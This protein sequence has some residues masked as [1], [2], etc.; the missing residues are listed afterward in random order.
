MPRCPDPQSRAIVESFLHNAIVLDDIMVISQKGESRSDPR[1]HS[2]IESPDYPVFSDPS[3]SASVAE[4]SGV[5]LH[6]DTVINGFADLGIVCAALTADS[7]GGFSLRT[8]KAAV[9][10]DI[11]VLDWT[12]GTS[13]GS[14]TLEVMKSI[15]REDE[16]NPRLRLI[17]IYTGE[18]NLGDIAEQVQRALRDFNGDQNPTIEEKIRVSYGQVRVVIVAKPGTLN[19]HLVELGYEEVSEEDLA[20][21][22]VDEF[23]RLTAG[24][25]RNVALAGI[26]TI[27]KNS[28][29]VLARFDSTLDPAYL[30]HR[31]LLPHPPDAEDHLVAALASEF[32]SIL[33][34]DRPGG[35]AD[36]EAIDRWLK[37]D[38][39]P[40]ISQRLSFG[41]GGNDIER[42]L[43]LLRDGIAADGVRLPKGGKKMVE[44]RATEL[45]S[46]DVTDVA[47]ANHQFAAL[48][49]L[50]TRYPGQPPRLTIG[51]VLCTE[52]AN[53]RQFLLC[54]QP[55]CDSI[56]LDCRS[57]FVFVPL[58]VADDGGRKV[59]FP[60]VV[61]IQGGE[62]QQLG[63]DLRPLELVV[64]LFCPGVNPPGEI[65]AMEEGPGEF[66]FKDADGQ[67]Y[68]WIAELK[69]EHAFR[70]AGAIASA[71]ARP[72]PNDAE[73][74]RR[75]GRSAQ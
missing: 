44:P 39:A 4:R 28:H 49:N 43:D 10:A 65:L 23:A 52:A 9:R 3:D 57:R 19:P 1:P 25:I 73:W 26:A 56:R 58:E 59:S 50:K 15:L 55:K 27:R 68:R 72:G 70:V 29:R 42:W 63:I 12:I 69:D 13:V 64:R 11:V 46:E 34:D 21:R 6:A 66:Y 2:P 67:R 53:G 38:G 54:L 33:E 5:P 45:F 18:Q 47:L 8:V 7:S 61:K 51:A 24:L 22:L 20:D 17:A 74:L 16:S 71:L 14:K 41:E 60:L 31:M 37:R 75:A 62:W 32:H 48:L 40:D 30:G 35:H 36:I